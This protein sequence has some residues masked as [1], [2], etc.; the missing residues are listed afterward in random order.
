MMPM[1]M[2]S[3]APNTLDVARV[4]AKPVATLPIN[5]RRDCIEAPCIALNKMIISCV[6][7]RFS[8]SHSFRASGAGLGDAGKFSAAVAPFFGCGLEPEELVGAGSE[9][10]AGRAGRDFDILV[11]KALMAW[12]HSSASTRRRW[13]TRHS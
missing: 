8:G 10:V 4:P 2:R 11:R 13:R 1:R 6:S 12:S 9:G 7:L 3:L 5:T